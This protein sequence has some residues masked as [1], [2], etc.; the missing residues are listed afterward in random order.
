MRI[1]L[2]LCAVVAVL[3]VLLFVS[4]PF[5]TAKAQTFERSLPSFGLYCENKNAITDGNVKYV[6]DEN[7]KVVE[8]SQYSINSGTFYIPFISSAFNIP[9]IVTDLK[10]ELCYGEHIPF[11]NEYSYNFYSSDLSGMTGTVYTLNA[12]S[13]TFTVDFTMLE[14]QTCICRFTPGFRMIM[15]SKHIVSTIK[16]AQVGS[17]YEVLILDG[18]CIT[19][20]SSATVTKETVTVKEYVDRHYNE[21]KNFYSV[22][23]EYTP[24]LFYAL[25]N[26]SVVKGIN[27]EF[28]DF[29]FDSFSQLRFNAYKIE[30]PSPCTIN[31]S[32]P[33]DVQ[34]NG[35]FNPA[36]YMA[37]RM[38]T[39]SYSID[40]TVELN[41]E[42]PFVI[43]SS[44]K[45]NKQSDYV[46]TAEN[47]TDDFY[48]VFSSSE[49]PKSIYAVNNKMEPWRIALL[50]VA[51][52]LF[53]IFIALI[54]IAI[55]IH[56]KNKN[57]RN[58]DK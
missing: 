47:V 42:L 53:C 50:A 49:K 6:V 1:K 55:I 44:V 33:V 26:L 18:D 48:F 56:I 32:M 54:T 39:G 29:F 12:T 35:S 41:S 5:N 37:D 9:E 4:L 21:F 16:N 31:Y 58:G 7:G 20:E 36:I 28:F 15:D 3:L 11:N 43:E 14:N 51:G 19:F 25:A 45:M 30:V 27:Y 23:G 38:A 22:G 24:N 8:Y 52:V 40:Y 13:D 2:K 10:T 46:Y 34:K 57:L 17:T